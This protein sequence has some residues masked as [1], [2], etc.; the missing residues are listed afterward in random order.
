MWKGQHCTYTTHG[1]DMTF[2]ARVVRIH[3]DGT[4]TVKALF[5]VGPDGKDIPGYLGFEYRISQDDIRA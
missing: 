1:G 5:Q 2:R 4:V 3:R